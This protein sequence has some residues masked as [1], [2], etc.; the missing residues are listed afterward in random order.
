MRI[1]ILI[2]LVFI[3]T[4]NTSYPHKLLYQ[5]AKNFSLK[6]MYGK[7]ITLSM[8]RDKT[9]VLFIWSLRCLSCRKY[10]KTF[11]RYHWKFYKRGLRIIAINIDNGKNQVKWIIRRYKL[12]YL[13]LVSNGNWASEI[14]NKYK[15]DNLPF[16]VL[17]DR[18]G[19]IRYKGH[20]A[21]ITAKF[22]K[23]AVNLNLTSAAA[24]RLVKLL[25]TLEKNINYKAQKKSWNFEY[26]KKWLKKLSGRL[27][28]KNVIDC[29]IRLEK[30]LFEIYYKPYWKLK[31]KIWH[32][33]LIKT[34]TYKN[35]G[36]YLLILYKALE[37]TVFDKN[38]TAKEKDKWLKTL[39]QFIRKTK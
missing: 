21:T 12:R 38:L 16:A 36:A 2:S 9:V 15:V 18:Q 19:S 26:R 37:K 5:K 29:F 4:I 25:L 27:F 1:K 39:Q 7:K 34:K 10:L 6:N 35:L 14:V 30:S 23:N 20:P 22:I 32:K 33:K 17:I 28:L 24:I 11:N 3:F 13:F 31:R 8:Y